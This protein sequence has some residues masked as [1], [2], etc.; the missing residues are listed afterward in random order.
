MRVGQN[1]RTGPRPDLRSRGPIRSAL[2]PL[3]GYGRGWEGLPAGTN[4]NVPPLLG[5]PS[6]AIKIW[7]RGHLYGTFTSANH[8]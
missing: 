8:L 4:Y 5:V 3:E 1:T 2:G 6:G 7:P